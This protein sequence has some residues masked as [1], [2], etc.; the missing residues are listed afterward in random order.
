MPQIRVFLHGINQYERLLAKDI[1]VGLGE[2]FEE[3]IEAVPGYVLSDAGSGDISRAT[4]L[5]FIRGY[6]LGSQKS[7]Y[8]VIFMIGSLAHYYFYTQDPTEQISKIIDDC[9]SLKKV[10]K[11]MEA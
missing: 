9:P 7:L 2:T 3:A 6:I 4:R 11:V 5:G 10:K 8:E 1:G